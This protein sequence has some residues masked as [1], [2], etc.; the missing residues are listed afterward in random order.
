MCSH[1]VGVVEA[2]NPAGFDIVQ[3]L[4]NQALQLDEFTLFAAEQAQSGGHDR[5]GVFVDAVTDEVFHERTIFFSQVD[6]GH[7]DLLL[8]SYSA[9]FSR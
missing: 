1:I 6:L 2:H 7:F 3:P 5:V 4:L 9:A 8:F